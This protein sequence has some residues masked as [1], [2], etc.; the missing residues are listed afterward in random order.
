MSAFNNTCND[1][2]QSARLDPQGRFSLEGA[3]LI[4]DTEED[5]HA[6]REHLGMEAFVFDRLTDQLPP[7]GLT[8][9][10]LVVSAHDACARAN[11]LIDGGATRMGVMFVDLAP[12]QGQSLR[13][14]ADGNGSRDYLK[15][16]LQSPSDPILHYH[17]RP[18]PAWEEREAPELIPCGDEAIGDGLI[19]Q[20][21]SITTW[22]G[23]YGS[24]KS[25]LAALFA[26]KQM[27]TPEGKAQNLKTSICAFEDDLTDFKNRSMAHVLRG[28]W[29][30]QDL[31]AV[32]ELQQ[33]IWWFDER[34]PRPRGLD[35]WKDRVHIMTVNHGVRVHIIDPWTAH[36]PDFERGEEMPSYVNRQMNDLQQFARELKIAIHV[37]AHTPKA[38]TQ[39]IGKIK[40][41]RV[42]DTHG[43]GD[44][45]KLSDYG[46]CVVSSPYLANLKAG[47]V[48]NDH[49]F[50]DADIAAANA[51][52]PYVDVD[53]HMIVAIDKVK[54]R[55]LMGRPGVYAFAYDAAR[56]DII[57]DAGASMLVRKIWSV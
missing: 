46:I 32:L 56:N 2:Q 8:G 39:G 6:A 54:R 43:S 17:V 7:G 26:M 37:V 34:L 10:I 45:G 38:A 15:W 21:P 11:T 3:I 52:T 29:Q 27:L 50:D 9:S 1:R 4:V 49:D 53:S 57:F 48:R 14:L 42:N 35:G 25:T 24:G 5:A 16:L 22:V 44:F 51:C 13:S 33:R 23:D 19:W 30:D 40:P 41:I 36:L 20:L 31:Q 55:G 12:L 18:L 28:N 47:K